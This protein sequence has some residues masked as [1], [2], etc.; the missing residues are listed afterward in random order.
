MIRADHVA[1]P[2]ELQQARARMREASSDPRSWVPH[3][4][5]QREAGVRACVAEWVVADLLEVPRPLAPMRPDGGVDLVAGGVAIEVKWN[6]YP[7][8]DF[9][10]EWWARGLRAGVGVLVTPPRVRA[11]DAFAVRGWLTRGD[12]TY[13]A[14]RLAWQRDG[15]RVGPGVEQRFLRPTEEL[16]SYLGLERR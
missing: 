13:R 16:R 15:M 3:A 5:E 10:L 8:G 12:F 14:H 1:T 7:S 6:Q 11:F 9:Y 4:L 2:L